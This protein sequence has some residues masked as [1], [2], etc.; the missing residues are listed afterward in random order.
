VEALRRG[1][2][3]LCARHGLAQKLA[4]LPSFGRAKEK[5]ISRRGLGPNAN[6]R[7]TNHPMVNW[8]MEV[9]TVR[10]I[11][12][13]LKENAAFK[14]IELSEIDSIL[15]HLIEIDF[16]EKLQHEVVIGVEGEKVVNSRE[17]YSVFK[18]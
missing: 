7:P 14:Q 18:T 11:T 3:F 15:T 9:V 17:F 2:F 10:S 6:I 1:T 13:Q 16:L 8:K 4:F 5:G 12:N